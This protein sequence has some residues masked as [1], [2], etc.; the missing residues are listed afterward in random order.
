[1]NNLS[2]FLSAAIRAQLFQLAVPAVEQQHCHAPLAHTAGNIAE[3]NGS[4]FAA[5]ADRPARLRGPG[6]STKSRCIL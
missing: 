2:F 3:S 4:W 6:P 1:M 5:K